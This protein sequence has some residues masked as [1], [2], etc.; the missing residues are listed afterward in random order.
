[1]SLHTMTPS[2][3]Y[4]DTDGH[5]DAEPSRLQ[6]V[7]SGSGLLRL[8]AMLLVVL[9]LGAGGYW[10]WA[11][12]VK[13]GVVSVDSNPSGAE[14]FVDGQSRGMTPITLSL[15][16]GPHSLELRRRGASR[17]ISLDVKAGEQASQQIDLTNIRAV[18]TLVVNSQPKGAKVLVDGRD[19]GVTP[20]TLSDMS[21]GAHKVV[22]QGAQGTISKDIQIQ[23]GGTVSVD[24]GIFSG[25]IAVFAPFDLQVYERKR[26]I[27]STEQ[28][29]IMLPA[30]RHE[31][32]FV[33]NQ[34]GFRD[35]RTVDVG[36]GATIP[37]SI[38]KTEGTLRVD[39]PEGSEIFIDGTR[40]GE[41]PLGEQTVTLGVREVLVKHPQLGQ[42]TVSATVTSSAPADVKVEFTP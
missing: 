2:V 30:G 13:P 3:R 34:R 28:E 21:V 10:Y 7:R 35:T 18:G 15:S 37:I 1:M 4:E 40:V 9:G 22:L 6:S 20:L 5:E 38:D 12:S 42:K 32:E 39:A 41:A 31:L 11:N 33:N 16:P 14:V 27:G 8:V 25:W 24:E 36:P 19:R 17:E 23:A 26:S 29:R